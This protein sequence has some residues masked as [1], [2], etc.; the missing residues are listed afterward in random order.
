METKKK[1]LT[2]RGKGDIMRETVCGTVGLGS[3]S[4]TEAEN[5]SSETTL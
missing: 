1:G 2:E 3:N 4:Y 5:W